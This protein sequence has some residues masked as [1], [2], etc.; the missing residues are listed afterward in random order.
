MSRASVSGFA[1]LMIVMPCCDGVTSLNSLRYEWPAGFARFILQAMNPGIEDLTGEQHSR[2][3]PYS[4]RHCDGF[5]PTTDT[6]GEPTPASSA[7]DPATHASHGKVLTQAAWT[8]LLSG[9]GRWP[10]LEVAE[11]CSPWRSSSGSWAQPRR[12]VGPNSACRFCVPRASALLGSTPRGWISG[13]SSGDRCEEAWRDHIADWD[14][15]FWPYLQSTRD[16]W[17]PIKRAVLDRLDK[18]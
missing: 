7:L 17:Q 14:S 8:L 5:G 16:D 4:G 1:N 2:R 3:R 12:A 15:T 6:G 11:P 13:R 18:G 10:R 9:L